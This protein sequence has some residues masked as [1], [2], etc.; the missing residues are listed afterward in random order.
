MNCNRSAVL[1]A[2][3]GLISMPTRS[4]NW[5]FALDAGSARMNGE[6]ASLYDHSVGLRAAWWTSPRWAI[7]TGIAQTDNAVLHED[8]TG[9]VF[10]VGPV[11]SIALG[12]RHHWP[13]SERTFAIVRGGAAYLRQ[14]RDNYVFHD[15][16]D[17]V[18]DYY[19]AEIEWQRVRASSTAPYL[20]VG[21]G[22]RW[23]DRW[24]SSVELT[25]TFADLAN[26]CL[27]DGS[28]CASGSARLDTATI[29]ISF[30]FD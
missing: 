19:Y 28:A 9:S 10:G 26:R 7:E 3:L 1:L 4:A 8:I 2:A 5:S 18:H 27:H 24:S 13:L 22:W 16:Y 25:R 15:G 17:P 20:G 11:R 30:D 6:G 14:N 29:G 23:D 12:A 21:F